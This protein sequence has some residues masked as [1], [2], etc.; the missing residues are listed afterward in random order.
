MEGTRGGHPHPRTL[1][2][3]VD[4]WDRDDGWMDGFPPEDGG[5]TPLE[6]VFEFTAREKPGRDYS[7]KG[8]GAQGVG[9]RGLGGKHWVPASAGKGG[10]RGDWEQREGKSEG[11]W[12]AG[13][14]EG[15]VGTAQWG[16]G[17]RE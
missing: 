16:G 5:C 12:Q 2:G 8:R 13:G 15:R 14:R 17:K 1:V 7:R 9:G 6:G 3:D 10:V 11:R 4:F